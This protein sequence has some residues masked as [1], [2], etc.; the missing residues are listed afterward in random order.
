MPS[1]NLRGASGIGQHLWQGQG[2]GKISPTGGRASGERCARPPG[3]IFPPDL[4]PFSVT[5]M[6]RA[7][8][9]WSKRTHSPCKFGT[10]LPAIHPMLILEAC[11]MQELQGHCRSPRPRHTSKEGLGSRT[12]QSAKIPEGR[13]LFGKVLHED[14]RVKPQIKGQGKKFKFARTAQHLPRNVAHSQQSQIKSEGMQASF[15]RVIVGGKADTFGVY[16]TPPQVLDK[17]LQGFLHSPNFRLGSILS[18][19]GFSP[20]WNANVCSR[21]LCFGNVCNLFVS[22]VLTDSK[23]ALG[24]RET[25]TLES[26]QG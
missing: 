3:P 8:Q 25:L 4:F 18:L 13:Q 16:N 5:W 20:T 24:L 14:A 10:N 17:K 1:S 6:T 26:G 2:M 19:L 23:R 21:L 22:E 15:G 7:L 9:V 11:S 12:C